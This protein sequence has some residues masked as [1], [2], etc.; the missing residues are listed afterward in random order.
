MLR[1]LGLVALDAGLEEVG[2]EGCVLDAVL[3]P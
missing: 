2:D 3:V 1:E